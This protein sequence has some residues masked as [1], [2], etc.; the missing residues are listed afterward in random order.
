MIEPLSVTIEELATLC[1]VVSG[2]RATAKRKPG[3]DRLIANGFIERANGRARY[4]H[5]AA[6]DLLF[7]QLCIG[8]SGG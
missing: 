7:T 6:T 1:D 2:R 5:T 3:L 8:I 4:R